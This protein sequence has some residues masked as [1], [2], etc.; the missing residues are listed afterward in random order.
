[1]LRLQLSHYRVVQAV[2]IHGTVSAAAQALGLTQPA[3]SH[4]IAEAERRLGIKLFA[5]VGRRL[6]LTSAG[7]LLATSA[8]TI[9][10]EAGIAESTLMG[11]AG[12]APG[13]VIRIGT[14][15]YNSY[16][17]LPSFLKQLQQQWPNLYFEFITD[18][19]KVPMRSL[20]DGDVDIAVSAGSLASSRAN[21]YPLFDDQLLAICSLDCPTPKCGYMLAADFLDDPFITYSTIYE[22]GF[23]EELL[24]RP[25]GRRPLNYLRAGNTEAVIEMVKAGFGRS[26]LSRWAVQPYLNRN[27]LVALPVTD[28]GLPVQWSALVRKSHPQA[29]LLNAVCE[30]L[31]SWCQ[32]NADYSSQYYLFNNF[33]RLADKD[34]LPSAL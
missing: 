8:D 26:I 23:E 22:T 34:T 17:W 4:Q 7:E 16:R 5:R 9:L 18:T 30:Q 24:W 33:S 1:M 6:R 32:L 21:L 10:M 2:R 25:A 14:F 28:Q 20:L 13:E 31:Q 11:Q 27:E 15:A 12:G 19:S 29:E 3:L